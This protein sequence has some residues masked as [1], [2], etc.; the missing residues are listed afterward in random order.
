MKRLSILPLVAFIVV[1]CAGPNQLISKDP[2][3]NAEKSL[4]IAHDTAKFVYHFDVQNRDLIMKYAPSLH[5]LI[6]DS[7]PKYRFAEKEVNRLRH[8]YAESSSTGNLY[9]LDA[10]VKSLDLVIADLK[11]YSAQAT[12]I[13]ATST[14]P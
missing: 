5:K 1:G 4:Q 12:N 2:V 13:A 9:N 10:A 3:V 14:S 6:N 7:K 8:V 11:S